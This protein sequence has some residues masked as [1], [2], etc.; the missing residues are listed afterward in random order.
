M[1][2]L[3]YENIFF[4][5]VVCNF[6]LQESTKKDTFVLMEKIEIKLNDNNNLQFLTISWQYL[7]QELKGNKSKGT[8]VHEC[9]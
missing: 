8:L 3:L 9:G 4:S 6:R 5:K 2:Y 1:T 7:V